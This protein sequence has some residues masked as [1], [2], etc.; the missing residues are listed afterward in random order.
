MGKPIYLW[1]IY[2]EMQGLDHLNQDI[3]DN[4]YNKLLET[5]VH[6]GNVY[7]TVLF[8]PPQRRVEIVNSGVETIEDDA[9]VGLE[10][11]LEVLI[12][13]D[14][15]L[16]EIPTAS[17]SH[18]KAMETLSLSSNLITEV[19]NDSFAGMRKLKYVVL[20]FNRIH[21]IQQGSFDNLA[22]LSLSFNRLTSLQGVFRNMPTLQWLFVSG[23]VKHRSSMYLIQFHMF[24]KCQNGCTISAGCY[25]SE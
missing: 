14:N 17:L 11:S 16:T 10:E 20:S 18:L 7:L 19:R 12:L 8:S 13:R 24:R 5:I 1:Y 15:R 4:K 25:V 22:T 21:T 9:F 23:N 3:I 6:F 2:D